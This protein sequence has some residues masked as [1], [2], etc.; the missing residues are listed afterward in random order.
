MSE[1][2]AGRGRYG[3]TLEKPVEDVIADARPLPGGDEMIIEDLTDEEE[4][5]FYEAIRDA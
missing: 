1:P 3:D 2:A 4:R 5:L